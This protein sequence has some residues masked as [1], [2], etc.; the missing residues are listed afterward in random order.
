ML[1]KKVPIQKSHLSKKCVQRIGSI[2]ESQIGLNNIN[3]K[4]FNSYKVS[5]TTTAQSKKV[6]SGTSKQQQKRTGRGQGD[7][8]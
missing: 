1:Q 6:I 3:V 7:V 8:Y 2:P 5:K 4:R